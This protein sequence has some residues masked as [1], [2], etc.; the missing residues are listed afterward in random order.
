MDQEDKNGIRVI[1][2]RVTHL[3]REMSELK[4]G[5]R[6]DMADIRSDLKENG[7]A[8]AAERVDV[9]KRLSHIE[10]KQAAIAT[11]LRIAAILMGILLSVILGLVI[12]HITTVSVP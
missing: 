1:A 9:N 10:A 5:L 4:V 6:Q 12:N 3:E 8:A 7:N 2:Q 11:E